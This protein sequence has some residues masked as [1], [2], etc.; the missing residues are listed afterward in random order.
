MSTNANPLENLEF[1]EMFSNEDP[2]ETNTYDPNKNI[3]AD[4]LGNP[5]AI[6]DPILDPDDDTPQPPAPASTPNPPAD[7]P[8]DPLDDDEDE[9]NDDNPEPPAPGLE[10][11][12]DNEVNYFEVF[13]NGL[14]KA[15][16]LELE[17]GEDIEW[18]EETFLSKM[19]ETVEKRAWDTLESLAAETYGEAGVKLVE[20]LFINK[21]PLQQYLQMFNN[22][23]IVE[24][25][26]LESPVNQ[27]RVVR[28]YLAKTGLD[29]DAIEDQLTYMNS[30]E[31]LE[32]YAK[33]YHGKLLERMEQERASLAE[34]SRIETQRRA[35]LEEQ[36]NQQ[37]ASVLQQSL[38]T[39]D[40]KGYPINEQA[41]DE[42]FSF[43][44]DKPHQLPNGQRI[45]DFEYKLAKM[46]QEEP[47]KFLAVARIVQSDLDLTPV[48]RKGVSEET[49]SIFNDLK[50]KTKK[51]TKGSKSDGDLFQKYF[52]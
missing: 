13:G 43:V 21:A 28:L 30:N 50:T 12:D 40:I 10:D 32:A 47:E 17:E 24:N 33:K 51:T 8:I 26:N 16:V 11:D 36:R 15:G 19:S 18:T 41:A 1:F 34:Q 31:K 9:T 22:E 23:Q 27:E 44:L 39:G 38:K 14:A 52:K 49:N 6:Q 29:E 25:V 37:Y 35:E 3:A 46:R 7:P 45:S 2:L 42:L 48:K 20:D 5:D 4:I